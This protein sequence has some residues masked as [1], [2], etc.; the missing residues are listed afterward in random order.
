MNFQEALAY[1][2]EHPDTVDGI[3]LLLPDGYVGIEVRDCIDP[4]THQVDERGQDLISLIHSYMELNHEGTGLVALVK[5][6]IPHGFNNETAG[7]EMFGPGQF[8]AIT[9]HQFDAFR[10]TIEPDQKA[11]TF[12]FKKSCPTGPLYLDVFIPY[13]K[14][15][16]GPTVTIV[17][18][19]AAHRIVEKSKVARP[20]PQR[21]RKGSS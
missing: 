4:D 3:G 14:Q 9:G 18:Q 12:L 21:P 17:D 13:D 1:L 16:P 8:L 20:K 10:A 6:T 19:E 15:A 7:V 2:R 11:L 5:G